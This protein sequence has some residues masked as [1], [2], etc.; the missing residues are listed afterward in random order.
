MATYSYP[1]AAPTPSYTQYQGRASSHSSAYSTP[2]YHP[3]PSPHQNHQQAVALH[4]HSDASQGVSQGVLV[5][6]V[7]AAD[8]PKHRRSALYAKL[9]I[10]GKKS[11]T[12]PSRG[13]AFDEG[14]R[15]IVN[16]TLKGQF[17]FVEV[18]TKRTFGSALVL[19]AGKIK[20]SN[21]PSSNTQI[22]IPLYDVSGSQTGSLS[23]VA[24]FEPTGGG[25]DYVVTASGR[26]A[27]VYAPPQPPAKPPNRPGS[28]QRQ[29]SDLGRDIA[30]QALQEEGGGRSGA[31]GQPAVLD[32]RPGEPTGPTLLDLRKPAASNASLL[33]FSGNQRGQ[34]ASVPPPQQASPSVPPPVT[35]AASRGPPGRRSSDPQRPPGPPPGQAVAAVHEANVAELM[36]MG[37]SREAAE[38]ALDQAKDVVRD[39]VNILLGEV[40]ATQPP[41]EPPRPR[42]STATRRSVYSYSSDDGGGKG[43]PVFVAPTQAVPQAMS[44][45][46]PVP[47]SAVPVPSVP[48]RRRGSSAAQR[49]MK[50][51]WEERRDQRTGRFYY[52]N[53]VQQTTSWNHPGWQR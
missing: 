49:P 39:A 44:V 16:P 4:R 40:P 46:A 13:G 47:L 35:A 1:G 7:S 12:R 19:G 33:D 34:T 27:P 28:F 41:P 31:G 25:N 10:N 23:M 15:F 50:E 29:L 32:F 14:F 8:L 9:I 11:K 18:K 30:E 3:P 21:V 48:V 5:A 38:G 52:V 20:A 17:L 6:H 53:H 36:A 43:A 2:T 51:G 26:Q 45:P 42:K 22:T 24:R 37:F